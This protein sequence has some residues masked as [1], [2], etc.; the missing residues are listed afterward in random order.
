MSKK[1][2]IRLIDGK[3]LDPKALD[4]FLRA[5]YA[6]APATPLVIQPP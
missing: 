1:N 3:V 5:L 6:E 2:S 4:A